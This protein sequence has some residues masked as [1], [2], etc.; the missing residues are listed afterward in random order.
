MALILVLLDFCLT[1]F[2]CEWF[3]LLD[4]VL[5]AVGLAVYLF[6]VDVILYCGIRMR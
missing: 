6:L 3:G 4:H 2:G 5:S 1:G